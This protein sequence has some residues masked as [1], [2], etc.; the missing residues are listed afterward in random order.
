MYTRDCGDSLY[1]P[2]N[3]VLCIMLY[4]YILRLK[5]YYSCIIVGKDFQDYDSITEIFTFFY[6]FK[7][8][9]MY[10]LMHF[11]IL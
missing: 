7:Y 1:P 5:Y 4:Y 8:H 10:Y 3:I 2:L 11:M 9:Q 6:E